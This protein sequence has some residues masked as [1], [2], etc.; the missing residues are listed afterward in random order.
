MTIRPDAQSPV[1]TTQLGVTPALSTAVLPG[2]T[3]R[4]G[5]RDGLQRALPR[6]QLARVLANDP[7]VILMDEPF[8]ALDAF[9][10]ARLQ[11]E[12]RRIWSHTGKTIVFVTHAVDEAVT[13]GTRVVVLGSEPGRVVWDE[14]TPS[15]QIP[16][17]ITQRRQPEDDEFARQVLDA[18]GSL[19]GPRG[20][21]PVV[22][23]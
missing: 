3:T 11:E 6:V 21:P 19:Q 22:D 14:P 20:E 12:L 5:L 18:V 15:S 17:A 23:S 1:V 2:G 7:Q 16:S 4:P 9:N 10:R 13:L 8:A